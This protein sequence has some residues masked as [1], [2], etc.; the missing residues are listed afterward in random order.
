MCRRRMSSVIRRRSQ[1]EAR[2][3]V[4]LILLR[5]SPALES[6]IEGCHQPHQGM[7]SVRLPC[8]TAGERLV[9]LLLRTC[10]SRWLVKSLPLSTGTTF[11]S[12]W[13]LAF[14]LFFKKYTPI[15]AGGTIAC[16]YRLATASDRCHLLLFLLR[17]TDTLHGLRADQGDG[18]NHMV[19]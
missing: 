17:S 11:A 15:G 8:C 9:P 1:V 2:K 12:P 5:W 7:P 19:S 16:G 3:S 14:D 10:T 18:V 6:W 13:S 4:W